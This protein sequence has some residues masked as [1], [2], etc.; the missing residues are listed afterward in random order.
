MA[1]I[2]YTAIH[3]TPNSHLRYILNP[4]K[5]EEMKFSTAIC[6]TNDYKFVCSDFKDVY[7]HYAHDKFNCRSKENGKNHIRIHSYIQ[8]FDDTV[9]AE[10]A[11]KIG[12]EWAKEMFGK[13]RPVIIS[14]H[15]NTDHAHNHIAVCPFDLNGKRWK[16]NKETL[17]LA[18]SISDK[19]CL[20][21]GL[22]II[23]NPLR[24]GSIPYA[25]WLARKNNRS[26]KV[27]MADD[28]DRSIVSPDVTDIEMLMENMKLLGYTFTDQDRMIAKP[29]GVRYGCSFT[30]LGYG[31]S[32]EML[33]K[34]IMNK[35]VEIQFPQ[36][37]QL[38][39]MQTEITVCMK[40][41]QLDLYRSDPKK[42][43]KTTYLELESNAS[44]LR[45][46]CNKNIKS[47]DEFKMLVNG[48]A[49]YYERRKKEYQIMVNDNFADDVIA[50]KK[51]EVDESLKRKNDYARH[52]STFLR[53]MESD[54]ERIMREEKTKRDIAEYN[55]RY[56]DLPKRENPRE[57]GE[58]VYRMAD[59]A[60][61]VQRK[62]RQEERAEQE[63]QHR[64]N[65]YSR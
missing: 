38:W 18:R 47:K 50:K 53:F 45:F 58:V 56:K 6:C 1:V 28:I 32:R 44:L 61:S 17:A 55:E 4:Q 19:I 23:E 48:T 2:K 63:R 8:S 29:G 7:E 52:Y 10:M 5:N 16:A 42:S 41:I 46:I 59:W 14:T 54:Y 13:N 15:T 39:E 20:E 30:K 31:Y 26:W 43:H 65:Y 34:R 35:G 49:D 24:K 12:V 27:K 62:I 9:S 64:N 33:L 36:N 57:F 11:H 37:E 25:E 22:K 21:H 60:E 3:T 51:H 40:N